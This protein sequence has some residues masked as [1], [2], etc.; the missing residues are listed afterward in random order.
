MFAFGNHS[1]NGRQFHARRSSWLALPLAFF[2]LFVG[3]R[4]WAQPAPSPPQ[5]QAD[6]ELSSVCF[7]DADQGW[8]VGDRGV[9]WH[10]TDGGRSWRQQASTVTCR[11]ESVQFLDAEHGWAVGGWTHPYSRHTSGVVLRTLDGG[12][13]WQLIPDVTLP[14]LKQVKFLDQK[15]G[16][17]IGDASSLFPTGVFHTEDGGRTWTPLVKG[18]TLG[19]QTG[20]FRDARG[21]VVA[22]RGGEL[23]AVTGMEI[24]PT[25]TGNFGLRYLRRLQLHGDRGWLVG[26][27]GLA[28][29]SRDSG[30]TWTTPPAAL[31]EAAREIDFRGLAMVGNHCWLAGAPGSTVVHSGDG[32]QSWQTFSTDQSVPLRALAFVDERRG[33]A[34][35]ALGMI[36]A[37]TDGGRTW[38]MQRCGGTR[39]ALLGI[40]SEPSRV[41]LEIV[42]LQAGNDAYLTA[43]EIL[44]R[45]DQDAARPLD[46]SLPDRTHEALVAAGGSQADTAWQFPLR[47]AGLPQTANGVMNYWNQASDGK[48]AQNLERHLVQ[49]IRMWRPDVIVTEDISPRGENPQAHLTNQLALAAM[50]KAGDAT[51]Y[52]EQSSQLGLEPWKV[53]KVFAVQ[54]GGRQG[55]V[56]ITPMQ[57]APRQGQSLADLAEQGRCLISGDLLPRGSII[58]LSLLVNQLPQQSAGRD[59]F[60][61]ISHL[62]GSEA[63]R[64]FTQ[65]PPGDL[66]TLA[67]MA[68]KRH[69]VEQLISR[70][71][72]DNAQG[73]A[74]L[75]QI[76]DLTKGMGERGAGEILYQL[77]MRY[78]RAGKTEAAADA[79]NL[80][81]QRFPEHPTADAAATWLVQYYTSSEVAWRERRGTHYAA[82]VGGLE[83]APEDEAAA[84][85][86]G[87]SKQPRAGAGAVDPAG[88]ETNLQTAG[89]N[90]SAFTGLTP[91]DRAERAIAI[92]K[93]MEQS[94]PV[95]FSDPAFRFPLCAA[96]RE[97]GLPRQAEK[98]YNAIAGLDG[99]QPWAVTAKMEH[100]LAAATATPPKKILSCAAA[101]K[102]PLLDGRLDDE[103]WKKARAVSLSSDP[104]DDVDS[105]A[106]ISM[107]FDDEFLYVGISC[108]KATGVSYAADTRPRTHDADQ[109]AQDRVELLLDMDRDYGSF[110]RLCVDHRGFT[111][112]S[113]FGDP[114]WNPAW[115]VAAGGDEKYWTAEIAIPFSELCAAPP[116]T[117][118]AWAIG[119]QRIIPTVGFQSFTHPATIQPRMEGFGI[120]M[121]E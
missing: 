33:W 69:N 31:P 77:A 85:G 64:E 89:V 102:K 13:Q 42:A 112:D 40:F 90:T 78:H 94:R 60:S 111:A 65:P 45:R 34:V 14:A 121:F 86:K 68:Q 57:W 61:G 41:P 26:D 58:G 114:T 48:A 6:A 75:G 49:R 88:G 72:K 37:T 10:T 8:A 73:E 62:P 110:Y 92:G 9:I 76:N 35:G 54:D 3:E 101:R 12:E 117:R 4:A 36:L 93:K 38:R 83:Q 22:G 32:G 71:D 56:T 28:L 39:L 87:G 105:P 20:D 107:A 53:K 27:G 109:S 103:V 119:V 5:M 67:A 16:W 17:A 25:R 55:N 120:L 84:V 115:Y 97:H 52:S 47:Q 23:G 66:E 96:Y 82:Q 44:G 95:L 100:W 11:L 91:D 1:G 46:A 7:V 118:A 63:R 99:T 43:V 70:I 50:E 24:R 29:T 30:Y 79:L 106:A 74:W 98:F 15:Q 113:C 51:S 81:L 104:K 80:L 21:G 116:K 18:H 19:W 2:L 59:M 108:R